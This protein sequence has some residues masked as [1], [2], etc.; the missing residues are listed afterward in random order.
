MDDLFFLCYPPVGSMAWKQLIFSLD[1]M[2][3]A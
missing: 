2:H 1:D 3:L